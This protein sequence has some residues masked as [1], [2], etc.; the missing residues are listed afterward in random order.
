MPIDPASPFLSKLDKYEP[1]RRDYLTGRYTISQVA[2]KHKLNVGSVKR[3]AFL[4]RWT[5]ARKDHLARASGPD[6]M[7]ELGY[8]AAE[9]AKYLG[10]VSEIDAA[11]L[12]G[13]ITPGQLRRL[14]HVMYGRAVGYEDLA[15]HIQAGQFILQNHLP[16]QYGRQ[17]GTQVAIKV[18][19]D[20]DWSKR[21]A[22]DSETVSP[23]AISQ[24]K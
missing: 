4:D 20:R 21:D 14:E 2:A 17:A 5:E 8:S 11:R 6:A 16:D 9:I 7:A 10:N 15:P 13:A 22:I 23:V 1:V 3:R 12:A 24:Q 18:V 19:V